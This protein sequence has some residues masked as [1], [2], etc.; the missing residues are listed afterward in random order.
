AA[1]VLSCVFLNGGLFPETHRPRTIQKLLLT[2]L[3][4]LLARMMSRRGF[5][6]SFSAIFGAQTQPTAEELD[7]FWSL[8]RENDGQR[9]F[10]HL[11]RYIPER[12]AN[13]ERWV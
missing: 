2:P 5:G 12:R 3:G 7:R 6:R 13:R 4:P 11:I 1:R 8:I 9:V 10:H